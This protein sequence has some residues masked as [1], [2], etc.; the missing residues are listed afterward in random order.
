MA[1]YHG[2]SKKHKIGTILTAKRKDITHKFKES[3][4]DENLNEIHRPRNKIS[5]LECIFL[6]KDPSMIETIGGSTNYIYLVNPIGKVERS[7][8]VWQSLA[9]Q[10]EEEELKLAAIEEYWKGTDPSKV[11]EEYDMI[12]LRRWEYR[13]KQVQIIKLINPNNT[14]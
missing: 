14:K 13:A 1:Y 5:R 8:L 6:S 9:T 10:L 7:N 11:L 2:S 3:R 12:E 4:I